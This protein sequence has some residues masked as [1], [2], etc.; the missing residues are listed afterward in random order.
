MYALSQCAYVYVYI[1]VC[2]QVC[3]GVSVSVCILSSLNKKRLL[4][5]VFLLGIASM[6]F[7]SGVRGNIAKSIFFNHMTI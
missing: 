2:A 6:S 4:Y 1:I 3:G 7:I 5:Y